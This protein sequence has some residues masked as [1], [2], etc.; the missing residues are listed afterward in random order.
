MVVEYVCLSLAKTFGATEFSP[1]MPCSL[2]P[3]FVL[4]DACL[5]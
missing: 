1:F 3:S 2:V 5:E 4:R